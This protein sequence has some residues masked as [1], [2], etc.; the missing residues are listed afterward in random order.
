MKKQIAKAFQLAQ[1]GNELRTAVFGR[2]VSKIKEGKDEYKI[3]LRDEQMEKASLT[4]LL[5]MNITFQGYTQGQVKSVPLSSL[6][7]V[8]YTSTLGSVKRKNYKRVITLIS[9]IL[10]GYTTTT[11]NQTIRQLPAE[12]YTKTR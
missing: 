7:D 11:V 10:S 4:D 2:E 9:N 12:V 8:D 5:N 1:I 6:V 3:Q